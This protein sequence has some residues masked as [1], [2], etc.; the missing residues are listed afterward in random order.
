MAVI[1]KDTIN[2]NAGVTNKGE[3]RPISYPVE[4]HDCAG[5]EN[6]HIFSGAVPGVQS[7]N[8]PTPQPSTPED[9]VTYSQANHRP[10]GMDK[11][12]NPPR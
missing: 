6:D 9:V 7:G 3:P 10:M 12:P 2:I 8:A 5:L 4:V 1:R 11:S